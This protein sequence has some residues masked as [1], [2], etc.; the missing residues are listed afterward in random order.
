MERRSEWLTGVRIARLQAVL[1]AIPSIPIQV[2]AQEI[3]RF[4]WNKC[5]GLLDEVPTLVQTLAVLKL[6]RFDNH[7]PKRT[8][9]GDRL[10]KA[11]RRDETVLGLT[12]IR[13]GHFYDQARLI[14]ETGTVDDT[15]LR[16]SIRTAR[17]IAPQLVAILET[18]PGVTTYPELR[19]SAAVV[20]ELNSVWALLPPITELPKWAAERKEVGNRAEMY[21]VQL[22]RTLVSPS[23]I[24][25]VARDSDALGFDVE[26]VSV[27]PSRCIEVKGRRDRDIVFYFTEQEWEKAQSLKQRYEVQFWGGIDLTVEPAVEYSLLRANG[28]PLIFKN[29]AAQLG[30]TLQCVSVKW[31][32]SAI[33][34]PLGLSTNGFHSFSP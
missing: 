7:L 8:P 31:K 1:L 16:C 27:A 29:P 4:L 21:T 11:V 17:T 12:L 9:A 22:E 28:Y 30:I 3:N 32:F 13:A 26:D 2:S 33:P 19:I 34:T 6:V 10:A 14:L 23:D 20:Q 24:L 18:W 5:G 25:W 15:G